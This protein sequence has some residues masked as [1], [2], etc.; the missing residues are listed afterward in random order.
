MHT[1]R[2]VLWDFYHVQGLNLHQ[3]RQL[4]HHIFFQGLM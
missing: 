3:L 2:L 1:M 4:D